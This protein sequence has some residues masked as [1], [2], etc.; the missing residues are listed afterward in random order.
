MVFRKTRGE[1]VSVGQS[2][3]TEPVSKTLNYIIIIIG[4]SSLFVYFFFNKI[5]IKI[6]GKLLE[7]RINLLYSPAERRVFETPLYLVPGIK[8]LPVFFRIRRPPGYVRMY[9]SF[10]DLCAKHFAKRKF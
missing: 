4:D 5:K 1:N 2:V 7:S 6:T 3:R 8:K 10:R 9:E